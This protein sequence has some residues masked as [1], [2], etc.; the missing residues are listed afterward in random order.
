M[1]KKLLLIIVLFNIAELVVLLVLYFNIKAVS[2]QSNDNLQT[3]SNQLVE[4]FCPEQE[5]NGECKRLSVY[6]VFENK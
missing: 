4:M 1:D 3:L 6:R 5:W 2:I